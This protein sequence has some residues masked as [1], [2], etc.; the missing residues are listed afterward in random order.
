M[1]HH[2]GTGT[3]VAGG[4]RPSGTKSVLRVLVVLGLVGT[5]VGCSGS[6][7][8]DIAAVE[9]ERDAALEQVST[10]EAERDALADDLDAAQAQADDT[11]AQID[12][13]VE[14][15]TAEL[16]ALKAANT[17]LENSVA[18][19]VERADGAEETLTLI[20][21][22][23]PVSLDASLIPE[24]LPGTYNITFAEAY[25]DGFP[26]CGTVPGATQA[27]ISTTPE[28]FLR[29]AV[30]GILDAGLFALEGSLYAITD[31]FTALPQCNGADQRA[32][33]TLTLYADDVT[34]TQEG[35]RQVDSIGASIT[36][37][38][39]YEGPGCPNGLVFYASNFVP[40]G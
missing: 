9:A 18:V 37:D 28:G 30:P 32:R 34:I 29:V 13:A 14:E 19:E 3:L 6:N 7:D 25:C 27:T 12:A 26:G 39:P 1:T 22:T 8:D 31:S 5:I 2:H 11:Q 23:F 4:P 24:D 33:V 20:S 36:I 21:E 16:D 38:T 15:V 17:E 35:V 40:A 10:V